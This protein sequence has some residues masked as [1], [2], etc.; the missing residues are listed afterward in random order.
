MAAPFLCESAEELT[1]KANGWPDDLPGYI[2]AN[3]EGL[4]PNVVVCEGERGMHTY[5]GGVS[6]VLGTLSSLERATFEGR[7][8]TIGE[9]E[10]EAGIR[11]K[12]NHT[13]MCHEGKTPP[14]TKRFVM[15]TS[16]KRV[17]VRIV[18]KRRNSNRG[19]I[20]LPGIWRH[21]AAIVA[22]FSQAVTTRAPASMQPVSGSSQTG[23]VEGDEDG[24]NVLDKGDK[25]TGDKEEAAGTLGATIGD[26]PSAPPSE[27]D[28]TTTTTTF[29]VYSAQQCPECPADRMLKR[30]LYVLLGL[31]LSILAGIVYVA[32]TE[33]SKKPEA[34]KPAVAPTFAM[35][36]RHS[37]YCQE[38]I[39]KSEAA[40]EYYRYSTQR[41]LDQQHSQYLAELDERDRQIQYY[42]A[43]AAEWQRR[44]EMMEALHQDAPAAAALAPAIAQG[45]PH[46]QTG[47]EGL[48]G[49]YR[50]EGYNEHD[51]EVVVPEDGV[52]DDG[53][54]PA[55][56]DPPPPA[57]L[58]PPVN[59]TQVE[60]APSQMSP[61]GR[62]VWQPAFETS[63]AH[64][65]AEFGYGRPVA[66]NNTDTVP[67]AF[68]S[69]PE[70]N[71]A[72]FDDSDAP[73]AAAPAPAIAQGEPAGVNDE[74]GDNDGEVVVPE[75]DVVNDGAQPAVI[76]PPPAQLPPPLVVVERAIQTD[77]IILQTTMRQQ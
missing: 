42:K 40:K 53:A 10:G 67:G 12:D 14:T 65:G 43:M 16:P 32:V 72:H 54:Q 55:V 15:V 25:P 77:G 61:W 31:G 35:F 70:S 5:A 33:S 7:H 6:G 41:Q 66:D 44:C 34:V 52:A 3:P 13:R 30:L 4:F 60:A 20:Q 74:E 69:V 68:E 2:T 76:D 58:P 64:C 71:M 62:P 8:N 63:P 45:Q 19:S 36:A 57:Q 18:V 37:Q 38:E 59:A 26:T 48:A 29:T 47:G 23:G 46:S 17:P 49:V 22:P 75:D 56:I 24:G 1:V 9:G 27:Y 50:E 39:N 28:T 51:G 21:L 11:P 73:A